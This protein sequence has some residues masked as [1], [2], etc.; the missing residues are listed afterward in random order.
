MV[1]ESGRVYFVRV[2][3]IEWIEAAG[4]YA[5]IHVGPRD[6]LLR[7]TMKMLEARLDPEKFLRIH[8]SMIVN[9]ERIRQL[10]AELPRRVRDRARERRARPR[11]EGTAIG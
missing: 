3:E 7:E 2:D 9:V 8:R 10:G 5:R 1:R 6:H 4:N 11:A